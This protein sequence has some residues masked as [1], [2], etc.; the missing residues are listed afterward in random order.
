MNVNHPTFGT[1]TVISDNGT[2]IVID[3]AAGRKT[4]V[5]KYAK[6]TYEGDGTAVVPVPVVPVK[7]KSRGEKK[8]AREIREIAAWNAL[9]NLEKVKQSILWINGKVQ[10]D[11]NSLGVQIINERVAGIWY[12]AREKG[13]TKIMDIATSVQNSMRCSEKQAYC[14]AKFADDNG[15]KY[16]D[17]AIA[18]DNE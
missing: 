1:G 2:E 13:D 5:K 11:R 4:L 15:I 8:R 9:S 10:G 7:K 6:L 18:D 16:E 3:F 14:L 12:A 17:D